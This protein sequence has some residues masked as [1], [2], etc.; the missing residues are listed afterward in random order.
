MS[1]Q[2]ILSCE[3][4]FFSYESSQDLHGIEKKGA[5]QGVTL[6]IEK[7]SFVALLGRNGS[8]K[9]TLAK[10]FNGILTPKSGV[11]KAFGMDTSSEENLIPIRRKVG[12][13]FQNPENQI[14]SNLVEEDVAFGPENLGFP[15]ET[16]R[17]Y[18]DDAL[19][20][21]GMSEFSHHSPHKLSG[22]QKQRIAI[23]GVLAMKPECILFDESTSMLDPRGRKEILDT[24]LHLNRDEKL[25]VVLITHHMD[26]AVLADRV[27]VMDH[28]KILRD[29]APREIFSDTGFLADAGLEAP[30]VAEMI[31]YLASDPAFQK[32]HF[33]Q[34]ILREEDAAAFLLTLFGKE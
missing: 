13:V 29:G 26:E 14:V 7:G 10:M 34:G 5:L 1:Q 3:N 25:T 8:G 27:V 30:P 11:V 28:G 19:K 32:V 6:S 17:K 2:T 22:G 15:P 21:V 24:I 23:A 4:V 12:M 33:P 18:V 9:S 31:S 20:T 16:I